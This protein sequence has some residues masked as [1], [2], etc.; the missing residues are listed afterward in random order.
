[1]KQPRA[2][3]DPP[4]GYERL[5]RYSRIIVDEA[6]CRGIA[7]E[8][9]D[10]TAGEMV[11][12]LG[13]RRMS[14]LESLS[15][16]TSAVA[17]RRC[18]HK[19]YTREV[20]ARAGLRVAEGTIATFDQRDEAFL[21]TWHDI[22]VKPV[23]GEQ[24]RG[25]TVGVV[26]PQELAVALA[27]ASATCPEVLLE[28]RC[29]GEDLRVVVIGAEVVAASVRRAPVVVGDGASTIATL[30]EELSAA[31]LLAT[32]G[33]SHVPVDD[34]TEAVV[35]SAGYRLDEV[36]PE[37]TQLAVRRTANLH[38]G[39]TIHDVTDELHPDLRAVALAAAAAVGAPVLG[40]DMIVPSVAG[41]DYT[42]IEAN[43]RPGLANHEPQP[44]V[45]RFV[46]LL[47]PETARPRP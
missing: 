44:T 39:G 19:G 9:L 12:S 27:T 47:F 42:L 41:P 24:G 35:R 3:L 31:R 4:P 43:E 5:N 18:D 22:V 10:P 20:F 17:F 33:S 16:L 7:V 28:R 45:A 2:S 21:A 36:L 23:R 25:I 29:E 30:T 15:E 11:L 6:L 8:L 14:T 13:D 26:S 38:T 40:L 34:I 37:G 46:D 1:M 32:D